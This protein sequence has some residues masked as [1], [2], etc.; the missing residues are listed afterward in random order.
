MKNWRSQARWFA[1]GLG[2][3]MTGA[4]AGAYL[5]PP[6]SPVAD[7]SIATPAIASQGGEL[8]G[9][10]FTKIA[11]ERTP[12]VVNISTKQK[13][14]TRSM[15]SPEMEDERMKEFYDRFFPWYREMP[16]EQVRQSLGSGFVV[17]EDGYIL[18]NAHVV[19]QADEVIVT[20][21][22]GHN[23]GDEK[24]FPAKVIGTDPK[25]DIALI[26]ISPGKKL[27]TLALADSSK[28]EVGEWVMAIGNPF[29]FSQSVTV[30]VVSAKGRAIGAGPYDDFI[31]TDASINPGN[32]G[33][34]L[35]NMNGDVIGINSAIYTGGFSQGNIGIG[36]AVPAN[37]VKDIYAEL[38]KG[39]VSRGWL[40]VMIQKITPELMGALNL[41]SSKGALVGD[42]FPG[43]P[44]DKAGI[45]RGDVIVEFNGQA[46]DS[47]DQLPKLVGAVKPGISVKVKIVRDGSEKMFT[48]SLAEMPDDEEKPARPEVE[49]ESSIGLT[50]DKLTPDIAKKLDA[51]GTAGVVVKKVD[52]AGPAAAAGIHPGDIITEANKQTVRDV[53]SYKSAVGKSKPG[54][55]A[56][57]LVK[58]GKNTHFIA[59][60]VPAGK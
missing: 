18:T 13:V 24:E 59:V 16:K 50:V 20:F 6:R 39:K 56:L 23:G 42:V 46:V 14:K 48:L 15:P 9:N 41:K 55:V 36:F 45:K 40:G 35:L 22:D 47:N 44:A 60:K 51:E 30:G 49:Q 38:K 12:A 25:T 21:G 2:L 28:V 8:P 34:P 33:G 26:K 19:E 54:D 17:E 7:P 53:A 57:L 32:S 5:A 52:P 11:K 27:P 43:S 1:L 4:V 29:G 10:I 37:S 3:V 31:Q 58:R